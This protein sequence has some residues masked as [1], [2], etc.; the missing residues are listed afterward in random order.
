MNYR[1]DNAYIKYQEDNEPYKA[2]QIRRLLNIRSKT[3]RPLSQS[4]PLRAELEVETFGRQFFVE[5]ALSTTISLPLVMF[6]DDFGVYRE[7]ASNA[8]WRLYEP[9]WHEPEDA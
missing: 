9:R 6:I 4:S 5:R 7:H 8:H 1:Y 2:H 3:I